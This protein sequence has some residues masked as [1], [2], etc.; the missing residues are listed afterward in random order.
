MSASYYSHSV[1]ASHTH[2]HK[3]T[4]R[5]F[6]LIE[7]RFQAERL[8]LL[9]VRLYGSLKASVTIKEDRMSPILLQALGMN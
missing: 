4:F 8:Y 1:Q 9:V 7:M 5:H 6:G 2:T 3:H